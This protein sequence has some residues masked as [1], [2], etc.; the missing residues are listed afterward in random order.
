L[1]LLKV[2]LLRWLVHQ[3][4]HLFTS[5]EFNPEIQQFPLQKVLFFLKFEY[6]LLLVD[7]FLL[8]MGIRSICMDQQGIFPL[9]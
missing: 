3:L 1:Q 2:L 7:Q 5:L 4:L 6:L 8:Q 9:S